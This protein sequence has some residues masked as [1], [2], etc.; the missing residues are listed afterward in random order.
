MK[1]LESID[2][3]AEWMK[4]ARHA[5]AFTG[6]GISVE[7]G[8]PPFRGEGGLWARYDPQCLDIDTFL[9]HPLE[10]WPLIKEIFYDFFGQAKPNPAHIILAG[11]ESAGYL[12]QVI[13]QNI[14]HLHQDAGGKKVIEFHGTSRYLICTKCGKRELAAPSLLEILPPRCQVCQ[15]ILKPDF[16]FFGEGIPELA[17]QASF[18]ET[19][20]A[21]IW[22]VIGTTGE[23]QPASYLPG[24]AKRH[25]ARIIEINVEPSFFTHSVT[26]IFLCGKASEMMLGLGRALGIHP[27]QLDAFDSPAVHR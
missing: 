20:N 27:P 9:E 23:V 10:T 15:S 22:L 13:T 5:V 16:V 7:S 18:A 26:D 14:D 4:N 6:A 8:I 1:S 21:D 11:M 19:R 2:Q 3:A 12:K 24:D 17:Y 25:G